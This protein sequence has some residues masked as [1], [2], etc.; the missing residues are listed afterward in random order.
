[1]GLGNEFES[2]HGVIVSED[3][4]VAVTK[5]QS[6]NLDV[7]VGTSSANDFRV[8]GYIHAQNWKFVAVQRYEELQRNFVN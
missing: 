6:P 4:F 2:F 7:S 1:M 5:V 3:G 8:I